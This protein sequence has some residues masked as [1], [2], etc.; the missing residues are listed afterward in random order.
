MGHLLEIAEQAG[1]RLSAGMPLSRGRRLG[2]GLGLAGG[3]LFAGCTHALT[4]AQR[5]A[6]LTAYGEWQPRV[7]EYAP[8][9]KAA[10]RDPE[11]P[12]PPERL[13]V[14][15]QAFGSASKAYIL[16]T[17]DDKRKHRIAIEGTTKDWHDFWI[18]A[19]AQP[20]P[21]PRLGIRTHPG[22]AA[23][24]HAI[25]VDLVTNDR[26][27]AGYTIGLT[28][29][30]LGGA[31]A[32]LLAMY[33]DRHG[34]TIDEVVT[35]GQ[36]MA[37]D[38]EGVRA[39]KPLT[40]KTLRVVACDDVIPFVPP[41]G[42]APAGRVLLLL[43]QLRFE[44]ESEEIDRPFIKALVDEFENI[45]QKGKAFYGHRMDD[46]QERLKDQRTEPW[47]SAE[48]DPRYCSSK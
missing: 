1:A 4:Q 40:T 28:G 37:T 7:L 15:V 6:M 39:Y 29:H 32:L 8:I 47:R 41:S 17:D 38:A 44:F 26:L 14:S 22:F 24:A 20:E 42:Y 2:W 27:K 3:L 5:D 45:M 18:D 11:A 34:I 43:D 33:L 10:Y 21:D 13:V 23:V 36:P 25:Y 30:S 46:Y 9:A 48:L 19:K 16:L 35:F 31:A 12:T